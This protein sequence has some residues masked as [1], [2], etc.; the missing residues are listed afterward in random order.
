MTF[1]IGTPFA[2]NAG[3]F[4]NDNRVSGG[5]LQEDDVRTCPHCQAVIL[6][7]QWRKIEQ[8]KLNGGFCSRCNAPVCTNCTPKLLS[9]GCLPYI[10]KLEKALDMTVKLK[11]YLKLSGLEPEPPRGFFTG[12]ITSER[13]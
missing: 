12:I 10:A 8:G 11:T 2:R 6:M 9:E 4:K 1:T 3:Y 5:A 13:D 7:R